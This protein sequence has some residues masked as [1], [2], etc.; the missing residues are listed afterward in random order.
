MIRL[1]NCSLARKLLALLSL[2]GAVLMAQAQSWPNKPLRF[3]VGFPPAG[4]G[5]ISARIVANAMQLGQP[6]VVENRPGAGG[7]LAA[8]AVAKMAPD[9]YNFVV[10]DQGATIYASAL[11]KSLSYDPQKDLVPVA[12]FFRTSFVVVAGPGFKGATLKDLMDEA[13]ANPDRVFVGM[14]GIGTQHHLSIELFNQKSGVQFKPVPYKGGALSVQ[15]VVGGQIP[16]AL[17][18][19]VSTESLVKAGKLR[20][21]A[22]TSKSRF[23]NYPD[24]PALSEVVPGFEAAVWVG[25]WSPAG[26]APELLTR[27]NAEVSRV[28]RQ[29]DVIKR[30][31]ENGFEPLPRNLAETNALVQSDLATWPDLIRRLRITLD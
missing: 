22:V 15:D 20:F 19:L 17:S 8:A 13:R 12:P 18:G 26:L 6:V 25:L 10:T 28:L 30:Y 5:D 21:I 14:P 3:I 23:P 11:F 16:V 29:P 4:G 1:F 7:T 27:L 9:G 2:A 31:D 24:V